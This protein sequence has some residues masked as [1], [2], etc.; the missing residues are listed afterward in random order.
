MLATEFINDL[1]DKINARV[2]EDED[3][4]FVGGEISDSEINTTV[5]GSYD[6]ITKVIAGMIYLMCGTNAKSRAEIT[7]EIF[8]YLDE[9][10][11]GT[12]K[13]E[14]YSS[15]EID[16]EDSGML[17]EVKQDYE[18][19]KSTVYEPL[20]STTE[21]L[22]SMSGIRE[23]LY[24]YPETF[25]YKRDD[26]DNLN[27]EFDFD[28]NRYRYDFRTPNYLT[29]LYNDHDDGDSEGISIYWESDQLFKEFIRL[30]LNQYETLCSE[31]KCD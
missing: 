21:K 24:A 6:A 1:E 9:I 20:A 3:Y 26:N 8:S 11:N 17:E 15:S 10:K 31:R 5:L 14:P 19:F 27:V 18:T 16:D 4:A 13:V 29:L 25:S 23:V 30:A 12:L 2:V 22:N 28:G 7:L